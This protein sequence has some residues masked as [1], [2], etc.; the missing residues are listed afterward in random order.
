MNRA[1]RYHLGE[2]VTASVHK[3]LP[4]VTWLPRHQWWIGGCAN[5]KVEVPSY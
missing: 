5:S 2:I 4:D 3:S 1:V